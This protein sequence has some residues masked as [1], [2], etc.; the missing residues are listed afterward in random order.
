LSETKAKSGRPLSHWELAKL[1]G[2]FDCC[3]F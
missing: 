1:V 3:R 2:V